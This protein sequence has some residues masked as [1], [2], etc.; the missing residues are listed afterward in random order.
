MGNRVR[1]ARYGRKWSITSHT[2]GLISSAKVGAIAAAAACIVGTHLHACM[3]SLSM[4]YLG[5]IDYAA[6]FA[7]TGI[8]VSKSTPGSWVEVS[9]TI[10]ADFRISVITCAILDLAMQR[11]NHCQDNGR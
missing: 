8:A 4:R 5:V 11:N 1:L 9:E 7:F 10:L 2:M 6:K 3:V